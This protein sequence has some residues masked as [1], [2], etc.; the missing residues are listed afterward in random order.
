MEFA[1]YV[2]KVASKLKIYLNDTELMMLYEIREGKKVVNNQVIKELK[3]AGVI[4]RV[5]SSKYILSK[6]YYASVDK[7]G[8]Y[9]RRKGLD[10]KTNINLIV[11]HLEN[12]K[13][14]YMKDFVDVLKDVP[15]STI[16]SYLAELK[17][18][19]IIELV[20]VATSW[21]GPKKAFWR[22]KRKSMK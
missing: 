12:Y 15:K 18:G 17:E 2:L 13:K 6:Q 5:N 11:S 8:L 19:G 3:D 22:L 20:G 10:R 14:G 21:S 7:K 4:E 1:K 9:T 16:N